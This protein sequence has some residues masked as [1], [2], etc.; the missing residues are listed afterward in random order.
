M[1]PFG[2]PGATILWL[3][4]YTLTGLSISTL[5][6]PHREA[7]PAKLGAVYVILYVPRG[8]EPEIFGPFSTFQHALNILRSL[9]AAAGHQLRAPP[10]G[11]MASIDI[12][13]DGEGHRYQLLKVASADQVEIHASV[14]AELRE[15]ADIEMTEGTDLSPPG[16]LSGY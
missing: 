10:S 13:I 15:I 9:A 7:R 12:V 1:G 2:Q 6:S 3:E 16:R 4:E 11:L 8:A 14:I 5:S